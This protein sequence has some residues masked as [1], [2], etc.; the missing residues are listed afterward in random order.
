M[1]IQL[2]ETI[3]LTFINAF[4]VFLIIV[5][6]ANS[7]KEKI[8]QWFTIM[9]VCLIGWVD[10]AYLGYFRSDLNVA[11]LAYRIN[12]AFVSFFFFS[13]YMF[14]I[15]SFLK[16]DHKKFK[17]LLLLTS[18]IFAILALFTNTIIESVV[19]RDWG[20]E[21][22]FGYVDPFFNGFAVIITLIFIYY[23]ISKYFALAQRERIKV[24]YFLVGTFCLIFF[25]VVF[26]V[27][28]PQLFNTAR[29]Q[30][31]GDY[32]AVI[33]LAFTSFAM[34]RH[35]FL[36]VKVALTAFLIS[37]I[38]VLIIVDILALSHSLVE[39]GIKTI[40][41]IF[42]V[43]ISILLM[44][45]VLNE[46]RQREELAKIN[47][48]LD[49]SRQKY[50]DLASEQK[51]IIDVM[52]HEIRTPLTA[53]IQAVKVIKKYVLPIE[54]KLMKAAQE[55]SEPELPKALLLLLDETKT[56]DRATTQANMLV[57]DMLETARLDKQRFELNYEQFDVIAVVRSS[58]ELMGKTVESESQSLKYEI[59]FEQPTIDTIIVEAD[60]TRITQAL[61]ALL[62]NSIKYHDPAKD[63]VKIDVF[64]EK[65]GDEALIK[66][67][68]NG[69]GIDPEDIDKLGK[70]FVRLNPK[71]NGDLKRPGGTGL[72]LFVV[73][74]IM[75]YHKGK[76][77]IE[78][79]GIGKGSTFILQFPVNKQ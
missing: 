61:D 70:K 66:V 41:L 63:L 29:Y 48:A 31:F 68:D 51:D 15:H 3:I 30:H 7:A 1:D 45:S 71:T 38:G 33:F 67:I 35:K 5:V 44:R 76:L 53:I 65:K 75:K 2:T 23:L 25:N 4:S 77:I 55:S 43:V 50:F 14:Y 22:N 78:S 72:G 73:N 59:K 12:W 10:F 21:I 34:L 49:K 8:Y 28:S 62:S 32:S 39:Q 42:F 13:A 18:S 36:G 6:L 19:Q 57:T 58:V 27:I 16:I 9:T 37:T 24:I 64:V 46:I 74:G 40:I 60:K 79:E 52:G 11:L 69:I 47:K 54:E 26:N 17:W 56:S 20:N